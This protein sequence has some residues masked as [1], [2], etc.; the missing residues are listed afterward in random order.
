MAS[1]KVKTKWAEAGTTLVDVGNKIVC[2]LEY[3]F[4]SLMLS[5]IDHDLKTLPTAH[6]LNSENLH[7]FLD[8]QSSVQQSQPSESLLFDSVL[9]FVGFLV[10]TGNHCV[11]F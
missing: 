10:I 8:L 7:Y 5:K 6:H 2:G 4:T 11:L 3:N 9:I 1:A